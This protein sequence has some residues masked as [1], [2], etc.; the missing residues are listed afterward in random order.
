MK[1]FVNESI[2][3][4]YTIADAKVSPDGKKVVYMTSQF[5]CKADQEK[6]SLWAVDIESGREYRLTSGD[7]DAG[8]VWLDNERVLFGGARGGDPAKETK[9]FCIN[10]NGGEA[11]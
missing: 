2:Q 6:T 10:V 7:H 1:K 11:T 9:I 4:F 8:I 5:D 3:D